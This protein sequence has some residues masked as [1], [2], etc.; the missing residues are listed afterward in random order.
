[1][2]R[3]LECSETFISLVRI[4]GSKNMVHMNIYKYEHT[5]KSSVKTQTLNWQSI[6]FFIME[7]P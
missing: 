6:C 7:I 2:D 4:L 5:E 3:L 1:M